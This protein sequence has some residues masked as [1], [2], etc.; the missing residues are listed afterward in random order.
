MTLRDIAAFGW[1]A[2]V[3]VGVYVGLPAI[4]RMLSPRQR[5]GALTPLV[6]GLVCSVALG[7]EALSLAGL[8]NSVTVVAVHLAWAMAAIVRANRSFDRTAEQLLRFIVRLDGGVRGARLPNACCTAVRRTVADLRNAPR[9]YLAAFAAMAAA[10]AFVRV[11]P[12]LA[13]ARLFHPL[14]YD[15]LFVIR[16]M[17][18]GDGGV[19]PPVLAWIAAVSTLASLDPA[20]VIHFLPPLLACVVTAAMVRVVAR[21]MRS[22]DAGLV[23]GVIWLL[24]GSG[25]AA[26]SPW[27]AALSLQHASPGETLAALSLLAMMSPRRLAAAAAPALLVVLFAPVLAPLAAVALV[28]SRETRLTAVACSWAIVAALVAPVTLPVA[29]GLAAGT[30]YALTRVPV[31]AAEPAV[32][33]AFG[34]MVMMVGVVLVPPRATIEPEAVAREALE[35]LRAADGDAWTVVGG[36]LPMLRGHGDGEFRTFASLA[37][38]V[39]PSRHTFVIVRKRPF[40]A[41]DPAFDPAALFA[42]EAWAHATPGVRIIRDDEVLRVYHRPRADGLH[43]R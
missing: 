27:S 28:A 38:G 10:A 15:Q 40:T 25:L 5:R 29:L 17:I 13:E 18:D 23:A 31:R 20:R 9:P 36:P 33:R 37:A 14:A 30:L 39:D 12:A 21:R 34:V 22:I 43:G 3:L 2:V 6:A 16:S 35:V 41:S 7:V 4:V 8:I 32:V 24:T 26:A 42:A 1:L 11:I 19:A